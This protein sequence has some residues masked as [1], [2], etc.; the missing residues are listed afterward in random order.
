[1]SPGFGEA[2]DGLGREILPAPDSEVQDTADSSLP[3]ASLREDD[4]NTWE[5][6]PDQ[7]EG[8]WWLE[9]GR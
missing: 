3:A 5:G 1:M 7:S 9:D 4:D 8:D 2:P 6:W